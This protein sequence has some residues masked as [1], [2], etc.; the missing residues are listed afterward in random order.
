MNSD[1]EEFVYLITIGHKSGKPHEIEIWFVE[2]NNCYYL[3]AEHRERSHWVQNIQHNPKITVQVSS[4]NE[5]T[6]RPTYSGSGRI[7][8]RSTEPE[9]AQAVS[10][11]MDAK[12]NW[13]DGLLVELKPQDRIN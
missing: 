8:D 4:R 10:A 2:Y 9:L 12:Y 11:L 7:I 1:S 6:S 5:R 3:V 13:S